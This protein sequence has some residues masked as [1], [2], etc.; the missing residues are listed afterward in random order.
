MLQISSQLADALIFLSRWKI[1]TFLEIGT[2]NGNNT[3]FMVAYL[4]RFNPNIK[5]I[6]LDIVDRKAQFYSLPIQQILKTSDSVS[7]QYYDLCFIDADH[8]L[9]AAT[10]DY[11]NVGR[12][13]KLCMFHDIND[14]YHKN[15]DPGRLWRSLKSTEPYNQFHEFIDGDKGLNMMGLGIRVNN[16]L[17]KLL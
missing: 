14:D 1:D 10:K 11:M 12:H 17:V 2:F 13:S 8:S 9:P 16:G 3:C 5:V 6:T 4:K 7:G 15:P